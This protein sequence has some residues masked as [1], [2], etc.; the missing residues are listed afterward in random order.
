M[1]HRT[2][3]ITGLLLFEASIAS[4]WLA[5]LKEIAPQLTRVSLLI[6]PKSAP[7]YNYYACAAAAASLG[8]ELTLSLVGNAAADIERTI[9]AFAK[10][11]NGG[12]LLPPDSTTLLHRDVIIALA[13]CH[14]LPAVYSTRIF[15]VAG[16]LTCYSTDRA[17][18]WRQA[19]SYMDRILRGVKPA[20]LPVQAPTKAIQNNNCYE[21]VGCRG[22]IV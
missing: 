1:A 17:D 14:R 18:R 11:P 21:F 13:A 19:A 9:T 20:D 3:N 10:E 2:G 15:V 7:F 16:G 6:N 4:K 5:M 22:L 8:I 12:L